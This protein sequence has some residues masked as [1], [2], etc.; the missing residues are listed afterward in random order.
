MNHEGTQRRTK[1]RE[2]VIFFS[3]FMPLCAFCAVV[4]KFL[5]ILLV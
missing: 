3:V 4:V 5:H 2:E 1:E